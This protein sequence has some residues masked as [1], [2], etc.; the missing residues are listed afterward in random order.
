M[1]SIVVGKN[2][3]KKKEETWTYPKSGPS[4]GTLWFV[5]VLWLRAFVVVFPYSGVNIIVV[6]VPSAEFQVGSSAPNV[7][8]YLNNIKLLWLASGVARLAQ[9]FM[10]IFLEPI[11]DSSHGGLE[12]YVMQ[13]WVLSSASAGA[14]GIQRLETMKTKTLT[15]DTTGYQS[16]QSPA[17]EPSTDPKRISIQRINRTRNICPDCGPV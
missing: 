2:N 6:L 1:V 17:L 12:L 13:V 10:V 11:S 16:R 3:Q 9:G 14:C 8:L 7:P 4:L 15:P 5:V